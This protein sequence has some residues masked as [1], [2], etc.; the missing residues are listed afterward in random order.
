M[1]AVATHATLRVA[2][3]PRL[4]RRHGGGAR[5]RVRARAA[6]ALARVDLRGTIAASGV[7]A[8]HVCAGV[9]ANGRLAELGGVALGRGL[10]AL[11]VA[12]APSPS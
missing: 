12:A 7:G 8:S 3:D 2:V 11:G 6:P 1:A 10:A 9:A 4:A 5:R